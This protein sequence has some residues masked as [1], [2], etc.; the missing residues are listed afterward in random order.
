MWKT[1]N[2]IDNQRFYYYYV[3]TIFFNIFVVAISTNTE[4]E[5]CVAAKEI[6]SGQNFDEENPLTSADISAYYKVYLPEPSALKISLFTDHDENADALTMYLSH[7][8]DSTNNIGISD[9]ANSY[10][11]H[12]TIFEESKLSLYKS[13]GK[14]EINGGYFAVGVNAP[15]LVKV[16][17]WYVRINFKPNGVNSTTIKSITYSLH[18]VKGMDAC[19]QP[20]YGDLHI[21]GKYV[22]YKT[23]SVEWRHL[24]KTPLIGSGQSKECMDALTQAW[25][26]QLFYKC[27]DSNN[28]VGIKPCPSACSDIQDQCPK[29][30]ID[31]YTGERTGCS[32]DWRQQNKE[33]NKQTCYISTTFDERK[34]GLHTNFGPSNQCFTDE[35]AP[36]GKKGKACRQLHFT[37]E[38]PECY[39]TARPLFCD[40]TY[41]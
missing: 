21:C 15:H 4:Y 13:G 30:S 2:N 5:K 6:P 7:G 39:P 9:N 23:L 26:Y 32:P 25:C 34:N 28:G 12:A 16:G 14:D 22:N 24:E 19:K 1:D 3:I 35:H 10:T 36:W 41:Q 8:C 18:A 29:C 27:D 31:E 11:K 38:T 20:A 37:C 33:L 40:D 17:W